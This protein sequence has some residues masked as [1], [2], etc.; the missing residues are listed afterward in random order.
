MSTD[1][2]T[3][4]LV[5]SWLEEGVTALPDR[6]LDAVLDQVPATPQRRSSW[7]VRRF[8]QMN[9]VFLT[10]SAAAAVL[11]IALVGYNLLPKT[12][13]PGGQTFAPSPVASAPGGPTAAPGNPFSILRRMPQS[14]T[15]IVNPNARAFPEGLGIAA[16]PDGNLYVTDRKPSVSVID[17]ATGTVL[18][19]WGAT[20]TGDGQ[21]G[22]D[23][24]SVAVAPSGLVYIADPG[25]RRIQ[26]FNP[27]GTYVRELGGFDGTA[28]ADEVLRYMAIDTAGNVY[29]PDFSH[30]TLV[31]FDADGNVAWRRGGPGESDPAL[32]NGSYS[33]AV[34]G[35][36]K[37]LATYDP[38]RTALL[39]DPSDGSVIGQWPGGSL[40]GASGEPS[41]DAAGNVY[42][43]QYVPA[44]VVVFDAAGTLLGRADRDAFNL[45]P[46]PVFTPNGRAYTFND[47]L[48]LLELEVNLPGG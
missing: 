33:L 43:F 8:N 48:E 9:R 42:V 46:A 6:V 11:V 19:S 30:T 32:R 2:D 12:P 15:G 37:I 21:F 31:K 38:G 1:R 16:G 36:G 28:T 27:D 45:Y 47:D 5:R 22:E 18:R 7:P 26:V 39:L 34:M 13:G 24:L 4:R 10:A 35:D 25:N 29:V 41:V 40:L 14:V 23:Y 44:A 20:G 3:T 17:P